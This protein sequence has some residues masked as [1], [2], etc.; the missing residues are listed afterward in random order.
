[1]TGLPPD[2]LAR[3]TVHV[4]MLRRWRRR[5]NLVASASLADVWRRHVLDSVQLQPLLPRRAGT[6]IDLGSGAGFPGLVLAILGGPRVH[7]VE[8]NARK[9]AF[10]RAAN[11]ATEAG[12]V[13][14]KARAENLRGFTADVVTARALAPLDR[15]LDYAV[16]LLEE[17]G[18]CLFLK[19]RKADQEL[20]DSRKRWTMRVTRIESASDPSGVILKLEDVSRRHG[21]SD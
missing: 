7:L 16:P 3:L 20:T 18:R 6:L 4:E 19:G 5:V 9:C 10:L 11:R 14:H 21:A 13:V 15:L 1:M 17:G 12:A 2:V 8:S